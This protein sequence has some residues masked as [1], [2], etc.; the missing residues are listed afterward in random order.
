MFQ[1][2]DTT[3]WLSR[4]DHWNLIQIK[5][6]C[7]L[8]K[9]FSSKTN[10]NVRPSWKFCNQLYQSRENF[11]VTPQVSIGMSLSQ[12]VEQH[13]WVVLHFV[14]K[15]SKLESKRIILFT[16]GVITSRQNLDCRHLTYTALKTNIM[17]AKTIFQLTKWN[18]LGEKFQ[19]KKCNLRFT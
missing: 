3:K 2:F 8:K 7:A 16:G 5:A 9:V 10:D 12:A 18:C 11:W 14:Y 6:P 19:G 13:D 1:I 17:K 4:L 15:Q